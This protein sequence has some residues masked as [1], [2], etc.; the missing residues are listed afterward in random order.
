MN[1]LQ[2]RAIIYNAMKSC[3]NGIAE[4]KFGGKS[5]LFASFATQIWENK[6]T[7]LNHKDSTSIVFLIHLYT[8]LRTIS[9]SYAHVCS[10]RVRQNSLLLGWNRSISWLG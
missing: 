9:I 2:L 3:Y 1:E 5:D 4:Q 7:Y 6:F 8:F 10:K